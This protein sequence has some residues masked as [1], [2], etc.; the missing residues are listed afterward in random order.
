MENTLRYEV[1]YLLMKDLPMYCLTMIDAK[2]V[3]D[4][5]LKFNQTFENCEIIQISKSDFINR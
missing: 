2:D 5:I 4:V 1:E 3:H